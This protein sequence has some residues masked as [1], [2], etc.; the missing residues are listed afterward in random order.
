MKP[1]KRL[2]IHKL[3][4]QAAIFLRLIYSQYSATLLMSVLPS[5]AGFSLS[6][7]LKSV[8]C[9]C[10]HYMVLMLM[11]LDFVRSQKS[12]FHFLIAMIDKTFP[13]R[14]LAIQNY[15]ENTKTNYLDANPSVFF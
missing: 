2:P 15:Q 14:Q 5:L 3:Q 13:E 6:H 1:T 4:S 9:F 11:R 12:I 7:L 10:S 8:F